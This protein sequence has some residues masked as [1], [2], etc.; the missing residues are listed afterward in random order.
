MMSQQSITHRSTCTLCEAM[1]GIKVETRG[2]EVV[3]IRGDEDDPLS[4]GYI[5]PKATALKELHEDPDRLR[6]PVRREGENW[7]PITWSEAINET[8]RRISEIQARDGED[9]LGIYLGNPTIHNLGSTLFGPSLVE[10]LNTRNRFSP[11]SADQL[12][13]M[14]VAY[15]MFGHQLL[16]PVP[17]VDHTDFMLIIGANPLVSNGSLM[18]APNMRKR[19][20]AIQERGG[21]FVVVDPRKTETA[22]LADKHLFIRPATDAFF[23]LSVLHCIVQDKRCAE[24][25]SRFRGWKEVVAMAKEFPPEATEATTGVATSEVRGLAEEFLS[26]DT[27]VCYGRIGTSTQ[28]F[29]GLATWLVA[30]VNIASGNFDR[31]GGYMFTSPAIDLVDPQFDIERGGFARWR[32]RVRNLP[33]FA[34]ELPVSTI[35]DEILGEGEGQIRAMITSAG[36]PVLSTPNGN[37]L[38]RALESLEFMVSIDP[39]INET[40]RHADIILPPVSPLERDNY[41]LV[42]RLLAVRNTSK[43]TPAVFPAPSDGLHDWQIMHRLQ[44]RLEDLKLG[45]RPSRALKR[46]WRGV[47]G[48][49]RLLA[50]ALWVG[51]RSAKRIGRPSGFGIKQLER[52]PEGVDLG[53]L[54]TCLFERMPEDHDFVELAPQLLLEDVDRLKKSINTD[55]A[56]ENQLILIGRR[57]LRS[58]NSWMHNSPKMV[59]GKPRCSLLINP[60]DAKKLQIED[61][62]EVRVTSSV[63]SIQT[64]ASVSD[65]MMQ[66]VVSLPH[67][68]GHDRPGVR[69]AVAREHAGVSFNDLMDEQRIDELC[70]NAAF[71]GLPVMVES[72]T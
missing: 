70:G 7:K 44:S 61:G 37:R 9:A 31:A 12:P 49:K 3:A 6:F 57:H 24:L 58:N 47:L 43:Y 4:R 36:N 41:D 29:G 20:K 42:F 46:W 33:E 18:S 28:P 32:S 15:L 8:A 5:C 40:T 64:L 39:Y 63:G 27:A 13:H 66:G 48:P 22:R 38:D 62:A 21:N 50:M 69:L 16:L 60:N 23:L 51:Q 34:G 30:L 26:R 53:P 52:K 1:C 35:A 25:D 65:E 55:D 45:W 17:D 68:F 10:T 56:C 67:G 59:S 71:C 72:T 11:T 54:T 14:F 2:G 19:L